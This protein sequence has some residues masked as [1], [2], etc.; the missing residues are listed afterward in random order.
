MIAADSPQMR[1]TI[2][3]DHEM[4]GLGQAAPDINPP[5]S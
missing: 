2:R 3:R 4:R 5:R 1:Q